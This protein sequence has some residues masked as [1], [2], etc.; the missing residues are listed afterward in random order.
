MMDSGNLGIACKL[1]DNVQL[2][3]FY[4]V[5]YFLEETDANPIFKRGLG[6]LILNNIT[7]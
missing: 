5:R 1:F 7:S 3:H 6:I 4:L 2:F